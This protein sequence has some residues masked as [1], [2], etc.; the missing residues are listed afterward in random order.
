MEQYDAI[1][2]FLDRVDSRAAR[3]VDVAKSLIEGKENVAVTFKKEIVR[4]VRAESPRRDHVFNVPEG[5]VAYLQKYGSP[6]VVV[7]ADPQ[8]GRARAVLN[9]R[10]E[11]GMEVVRFDPMVH[12]FWVPWQEQM[13]V[14]QPVKAFAKFVAT[15]KHV[16][17][18]PE[19]KSLFVLLSQ[20]RLAKNV[21]IEEGFGRK[22]VNGV[23]VESV[24]TGNPKM[25]V[26]LPETIGVKCPM[27]WGQEEMTI[28]VDVLVDGSGDRVMISLSSADAEAKRIEQ[29]EAMLGAMEADLPEATVTLGHLDYT[30]WRY[31]SEAGSSNWE[32]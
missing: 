5:F 21:T 27:F 19:P 25:S 20:V 11:G 10:A 3:S 32:R 12:P 14:P 29:I 23:M 26:D 15:Q 9:E 31:V 24:V 18:S 16:I 28:E 1:N 4:P 17:V 13:K 30:D 6:D 7:L 2:E 22:S 8:T